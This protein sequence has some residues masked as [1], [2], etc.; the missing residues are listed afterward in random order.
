VTQNKATTC[1]TL[2]VAKTAPDHA[3]WLG[4]GWR[5]VVVDSSARE[6][7]AEDLGTGVSVLAKNA[8]PTES[9]D[10]DGDVSGPWTFGS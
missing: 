1:G 10:L 8:A 9:P 3:G 5:V 4:A 2:L 7:R 6:V